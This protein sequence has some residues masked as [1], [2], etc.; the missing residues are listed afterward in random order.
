LIYQKPANTNNIQQKYHG[1]LD[2]KKNPCDPFR[3][4]PYWSSRLKFKLDIPKLQ[5]HELYKEVRLRP[6]FFFCCEGKKPQ[7]NPPGWLF[8]PLSSNT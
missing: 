4:T 6:L 7:E 5:L 1:E 2:M 3:F 8:K